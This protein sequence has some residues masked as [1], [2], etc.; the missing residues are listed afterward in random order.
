LTLNSSITY[1]L[2]KKYQ[3]QYNLTKKLLKFFSK[4]M[5]DINITCLTL[6]LKIIIAKKFFF[7]F[8]VK[9]NRSKI[10]QSNFILSHVIEVAK[11]YVPPGV[12]AR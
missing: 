9:I 11:N 10:S 5:L 4:I 1:I 8:K 2:T 6:L 12:A 3:M 7:M